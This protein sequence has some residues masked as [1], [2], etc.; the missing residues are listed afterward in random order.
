M[1]TKLRNALKRE[2]EIGGKPYVL[3]IG[4]DGLKVVPKGK[5]KGR[6][7]AWRDLVSGDAALAVALNASLGGTSG[8]SSRRSRP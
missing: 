5:R 1:A 2:L 4:P 8:R 6:E 3:T 7:L